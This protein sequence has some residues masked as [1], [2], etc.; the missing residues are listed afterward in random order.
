VGLFDELKGLAEAAEKAAE[1]HPDEVKMGIGKL[2]EVIDQQTGGQHHDQIA[3]AEQKA[4]DYIDRHAAGGT[5]AATP[6]APTSPAG[7]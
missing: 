5:T 1:E 7:P 2:A 4:D 6:A 3:K